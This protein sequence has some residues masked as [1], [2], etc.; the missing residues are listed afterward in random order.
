MRLAARLPHDLWREVVETACYLRNRT[1]RDP[2]DPREL[3]QGT[4]WKS[5]LEL[6]T[7]KRAS[8]AYLRAYGCKAYAMTADA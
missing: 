2:K 7:K 3:N 5:P 1:P 4:D 8:L 6:F